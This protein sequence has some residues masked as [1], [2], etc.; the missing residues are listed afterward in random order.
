MTPQEFITKYKL[1]MS[2]FHLGHTV[3]AN[4]F[5]VVLTKRVN[6]H[7]PE[8][9]I[10]EKKTLS[11]RYFTCTYSNGIA[12]KGIITLKD[13]LE[14]LKIDSDVLNYKDYHVWAKEYGGSQDSLEDYRTYKK[15][16]Y[17][18]TRLKKFLG[19][20]AFKEFLEVNFDE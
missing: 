11:K 17:Q 7:R 3:H 6:H 19:L 18:T 10:E 8:S 13:I 12:D 5:L 1:Q 9:F 15:C 14:C 4:E 2:L 16:K 20:N